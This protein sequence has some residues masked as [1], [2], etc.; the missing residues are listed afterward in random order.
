MKKI[1][2]PAGFVPLQCGR[3]RQRLRQLAR[4]VARRLSRRRGRQGGDQQQGDD[5]SAEV[6]EDL[7]PTFVPGT[8]V[9]RSGNNRAYAA[10]EC[11]L[12]AN[13]VS[14]YYALKNDPA[15]RAIA[16]DTEHAP[17]PYGG[18]QAAGKPSDPQ[19]HGVQAHKFANA[20]KAYILFM[21]EVEYDPWLTGCLGYWSHAQGLQQQ[22]RVEVRSEAGAFPGRHR[23]PVL[24]LRGPITHA[25]GLG[26]GGVHHGAD[27][28][29]VLPAR[30]RPRRRPRRPTGAPGA[31]TAG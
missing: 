13:G 26:R 19:R 1:N 17:L 29:L 9:G 22:R 6:P 16:D 31:I 5:R 18:R 15:T 21:M 30:Q 11:W 23:E 24:P 3:R 14:L 28:R 2:K 20:A 4:L 7:Y 25:A 10:N 12:T 27:V 8:L